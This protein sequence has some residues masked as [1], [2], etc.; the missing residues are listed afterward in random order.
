MALQSPSSQIM[1]WDGQPEVLTHGLAV[2]NFSP[3]PPR[4]P[5]AQ[6]P[7]INCTTHYHPQCCQYIFASTWPACCQPLPVCLPLVTL[8][9]FPKTWPQE[10]SKALHFKGNKV[11]SLPCFPHCMSFNIPNP[12]TLDSPPLMKHLFTLT[13]KYLLQ[14]LPLPGGLFPP[15]L[16]PCSALCV[17]PPGFL[18]V[19]TL[20]ELIKNVCLQEDQQKRVTT[21]YFSL[22]P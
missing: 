8:L 10:T 19:Q 6:W 18:W 14:L 11:P 1:I 17:H 12:T 4:T 5:A 9:F 16:S 21:M 20:C 7:H 22:G 15:T 2:S 13:S 3:S